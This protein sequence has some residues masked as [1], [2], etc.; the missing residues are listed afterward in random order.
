MGYAIPNGSRVYIGSAVAASIPFTAATNAAEVELTVAAA[1]GLAAGDPVIVQCDAWAELNN[2]VLEVKSSTGT[3]VV[4]SGFDTSDVNDFPAGATGT[5]A[6]VTTWVPLP[7]VT[8]VAI[9]GGDQQTITFQPL[10]FDRAIT[11]NTFKTGVTQVYTF[12]HDASDAVRP[13]L[14]KADKSGS[15]VPVKFYQ[16]RANENRYFSSQVSFQKIPTTEI[17]AV[18]TVSA[19]LALQSDM[20]FYKIP[21]P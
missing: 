3:K 8:T 17:N 7:L 6:K 18:E 19:R 2:M 4:L 9:E 15:I 1:S 21:K 10:E 12:A 5:I 11:I 14:T 13:T 20:Q 16:K